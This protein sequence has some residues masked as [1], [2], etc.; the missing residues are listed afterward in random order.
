MGSADGELEFGGRIDFQ[1]KLRG[2][3]LELGEI[4]HALRAQPGVLEAVVLLDK[5]STARASQRGTPTAARGVR[6]PGAASARDG[7]GG[8]RRASAPQPFDRS[9][10]RLSE[11][12]A[13]RAAVVHGAVCGGGHRRVA[14]HEQ[15]Q[16]RPQAAAAVADACVGATCRRRDGAAHGGRG[17]GARGVRVGAVSRRGGDQRGGELLRARRQ[18]AACG[19]ARAPSVRRARPA[20]ERRRRAAAADDRGAERVGWRGRGPRC[21][22]SSGASTARVWWRM[23]M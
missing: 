8:R 7:K 12:R 20:G 21:L 5:G 9:R 14:A 3:R 15:R 2:Q 4:E 6:E 10:A 22:R 18:L 16:D 23:R 17:G 19:G 1:V 13:R 11:R